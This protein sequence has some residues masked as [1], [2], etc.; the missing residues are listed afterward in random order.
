MT[1]MNLWDLW[2]ENFHNARRFFN[3][4]GNRCTKNGLKDKWYKEFM[5]MFEDIIEEKQK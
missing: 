5:K 1:T 3:S 2:A 4:E